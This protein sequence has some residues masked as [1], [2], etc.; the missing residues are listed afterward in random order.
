MAPK[1]CQTVKLIS[2]SFVQNFIKEILKGRVINFAKDFILRKSLFCS[3][4]NAGETKNT[5]LPRN[6][7][8]D[9]FALHSVP[10]HLFF[11]HVDN[12]QTVS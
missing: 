11:L 2:L 7:I 6:V 12:K 8:D 4:N 3:E 5:W 1:R 10:I 9:F